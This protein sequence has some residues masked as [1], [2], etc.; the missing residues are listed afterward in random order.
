MIGFIVDTEF[1]WGFQAR[2]VGLSK[3]SPSFYYPPPTTFLGALAEVIAKEYNIGEDLGRFVINELSRNLLAIG[4]RPLNCVPI[5]YE[6][7]NRI[8][9]VKITSGVLYPNPNDLSK[10]FDS[11]ARGKT[12]LASLNDEAPKLRWFLVFEDKNINIKDENLEGKIGTIELSD[13]IFWKIHR[14]GSKE[15][16]VCVTEFKSFEDDEIQILS[17]KYAITNYSFPTIAVSTSEEKVRRWENEVYVDPFGGKLENGRYTP[18]IK[19]IYDTGEK[20]KKRKESG[21]FEKYRKGFDNLRVFKIPI[22]VYV[23]RLPEYVVKAKDGWK[24]YTVVFNGKREVVIGVDNV[25]L[26]N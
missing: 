4:F 16:R 23:E 21:I 14:L 22:I 13:E 3:T 26:S 10:S 20:G 15:S 6:D 24:A 1:V 5:K 12:I 25:K 19:K 9:A 11:P 7:L 2:I 8:I 18:H 17:E